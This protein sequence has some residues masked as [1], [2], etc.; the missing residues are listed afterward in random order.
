MTRLMVFGALLGWVVATALTLVLVV[1]FTL[2]FQ[3]A[4]GTGLGSLIAAW[5]SPSLGAV[6]GSVGTL[7]G[8]RVADR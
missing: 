8:M 3:L 1:G 4:W 7:V 5:F 2:L 6:M